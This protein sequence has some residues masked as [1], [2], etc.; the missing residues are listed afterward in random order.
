MD[1]TR[2]IPNGQQL[3]IERLT[4]Q[5]LL[6]KHMYYISACMKYDLWKDITQTHE[7]KMRELLLREIQ[8]RRDAL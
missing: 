8:I 1:G 4:E 3:E 2:W 7:Y 5:D 6:R